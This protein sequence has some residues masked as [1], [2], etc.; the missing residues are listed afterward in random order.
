MRT[1]TWA[2]AGPA[3][4]GRPRPGSRDL[5]AQPRLGGATTRG[6]PPSSPG[7]TLS[8]SFSGPR[9][10]RSGWRRAE[11][12]AP[13]LDTVEE[14]GGHGGGPDDRDSKTGFTA[15]RAYGA[16]R[17]RSAH[18]REPQ[19]DGV[20]RAATTGSSGMSR[21]RSSRA[22]AGRRRRS[23]RRRREVA[24]RQAFSRDSAAR[25]SGGLLERRGT[26]LRAR[27][28]RGRGRAWTSPKASEDGGKGLAA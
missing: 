6:R 2:S 3:G 4:A 18:E 7:R 5:A 25:P 28:A 8:I 9:G 27:P 11:R 10:R 12:P 20:G 22:S 1:L 23:E 16:G 17:E 24:N 14:E 26:P 21:G 19:G 15:G 13:E